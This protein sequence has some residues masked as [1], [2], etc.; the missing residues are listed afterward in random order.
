MMKRTYDVDLINS[1][2]IPMIND[3]V[4]DDTE[5]SCFDLDVYKDCWLMFVID[6]DF[7]GLFH[8]CALN[9][10]TLDLHCYMMKDKRKHSFSGG[11]SAINWI[12]DNAP[13]MYKKIITQVPSIYP[14]IK[15]YVKSLGFEHEGTYKEAFTKNEII[16]D[17]WLFGIKR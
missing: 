11:I 5:L 1:V 4:E 9:R 6:G 8:V 17:L 2:V 14:H 16:Y 7:K 3:V 13:K 10:T 12:R 15:K